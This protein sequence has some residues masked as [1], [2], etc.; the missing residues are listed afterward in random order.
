M[1]QKVEFFPSPS[2]RLLMCRGTKTI[3]KRVRWQ[4]ENFSL[5]EGRGKFNFNENDKMMD[6]TFKNTFSGLPRWIFFA[7]SCQ[8]SM[9]VSP[10]WWYAVR[11]VYLINR[12]LDNNW[13]TMSGRLFIGLRAISLIS[14]L[15]FFVVLIWHMQIRDHVA[16][17]GSVKSK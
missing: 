8:C 12:A 2:A 7:L 5:A 6:L 1:T 3:A 9:C 17:M 13:S 16:H 14:G 10:T 4:G 11:G 15:T